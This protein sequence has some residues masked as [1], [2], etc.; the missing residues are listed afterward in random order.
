MATLEFKDENGDT[1]EI[2]VTYR[3]VIC[4][5]ESD[6]YLDIRP[7]VDE[8]PGHFFVYIGR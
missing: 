7:H 8:N 2:T 4:N 3:C 1:V 5:A 6:D